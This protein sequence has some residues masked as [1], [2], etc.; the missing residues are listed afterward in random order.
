MFSLHEHEDPKGLPSEEM[1][2][3]VS[4]GRLRLL[5]QQFKPPGIKQSHHLI[6]NMSRRLLLGFMP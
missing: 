6:N 5:L 2:G 3:P 4:D 1:P